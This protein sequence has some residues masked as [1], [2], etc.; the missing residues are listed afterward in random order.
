VATIAEAG[1]KS[2]PLAKCGSAWLSLRRQLLSSEEGKGI[3]GVDFRVVKSLFLETGWLAIGHV[4][5]MV[6][7]LPLPN[8]NNNNF[9]IAI[10]DTPAA[11]SVLQEA[12]ASGHG[13]LPLISYAGDT[14]PDATTLILDPALTASSS[15]NITNR[16]TTISSLLSSADFLRH[17]RLRPKIPR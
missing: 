16:R 7:F 17:Q 14:T 11:L 6:Q 15:S 5:E 12:L 10:A 9:A 4:D 2:V 3:R 13:D 1:Q 8:N